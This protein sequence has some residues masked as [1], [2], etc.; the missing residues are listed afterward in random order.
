MKKNIRLVKPF[1]SSLSY[2][3]QEAE[4]ME[5]REIMKICQTAEEHLCRYFIENLLIPGLCETKDL[6]GADCKSVSDFLIGVSR[7]PQETLT[8]FVQILE[9]LEGNLPQE[10]T[11]IH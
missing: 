6:F 11:N 10:E 1:I 4:R 3:S 8:E 5:L 2:L 9:Q 7:L